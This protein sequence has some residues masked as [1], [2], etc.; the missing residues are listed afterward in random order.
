VTL[1]PGAVDVSDTAFLQ[2]DAAVPAGT[3]T[4]RFRLVP[5]GG[6]AAVL[7]V[8]ADVETVGNGRV[9]ATAVV[10]QGILPI[11]QF[12]VVGEVLR[13]TAVLVERRRAFA[14]RGTAPAAGVT[15]AAAALGA[16]VGDI[17]GLVPRFTRDD[18]LTSPLLGRALDALAARATSDATKQA[19][20][21]ARAGQ[22][23]PISNGPH[24]ASAR[25]SAPTPISCRRRCSSAPATPSAG[26]TSRRPAR[27]RRR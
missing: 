10:R 27:G 17:S 7:T 26:A 14:V 15:T 4:A 23:A 21:R 19:I 18:V 9:R 2:L 3:A 8:P 11:G 20:A 25:R 13:D 5:S 6:G 16:L 24:S 22:F 12:D 1:A